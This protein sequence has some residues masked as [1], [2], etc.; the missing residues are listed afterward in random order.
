MVDRAETLAMLSLA[1]K[2]GREVESVVQGG[3]MEPTIPPGS[4]VRIEAP[5]AG[6][7]RV[8]QIAVCEIAG[9]LVVHRIVHC[10]AH[11]WLLLR[12]DAHLLCDPPA[13]A[14]AVQG[15]VA[16]YFDGRDW[17]D[18]APSP[19]RS[20]LRRLAAAMHLRLIRACLAIHSGLAGFVAGASWTAARRL[21]G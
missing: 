17:R 16:Q 10:A 3:S 21:R 1:R 12:G 2:A 8:G 6:Q 19:G 11:G 14:S 20:R 9:R 4:R 18:P 15:I 13:A 7:Y 5:E